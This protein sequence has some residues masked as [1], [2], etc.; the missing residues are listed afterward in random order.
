[1]KTVLVFL[2]MCSIINASD[3]Y[4]WPVTRVLDG[5][6][7]EI[8]VDFLPNELGNRLYVRVWGVDTPEKG[9]RAKSEN[10]NEMGLKASQFTKDAIKNAST[11]EIKVIA[12]D[13]FG[14]R[15]LGD[16]IIDGKS[17]RQMLL[18]NGFAR[19]YYGT[20]KENW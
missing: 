20:K 9:W 5:D 3:L 12:W 14:G 16:I 15:I 4:K 19:E 18:D 10:E 11:I 2:C 6:T 8:K 13:K 1:M 7:V 17:L